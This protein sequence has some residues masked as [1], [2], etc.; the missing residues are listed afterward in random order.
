MSNS[1]VPLQPSSKK[2][3]LYSKWTIVILLILLLGV[4]TPSSI[5][6]VHKVQAETI[7]KEQLH[8][9]Q[10]LIKNLE[11]TAFSDHQFEQNDQG[12]MILFTDKNL[13]DSVKQLANTFIEKEKSD[14]DLTLA[15]THIQSVTDQVGEVKTVLTNYTW[16]SDT[17]S[18]TKKPEKSL[19]PTYVDAT[20]Q[21]AITMQNLVVDEAHLAAIRLAV[22]QKLLDNAKDPDAILD[23][24]LALPD[25]TWETQM[26]YTPT[27]LTITLPDNSGVEEDK[28]TLDYKTIARAINPAY[29]DPTIVA[30]F[31]KNEHTG[32]KQIALTFDDG[33]NPATT[34]SILTTLKAKNVHATFFQLGEQVAMYPELAK[35]VHDEG[36]LIG[37]HTYH[38]L[39]LVTQN[40]D[41]IKEEIQDTDK[42]IFQASGIL[43]TIVRPPYG[44]VNQGVADISG[45]P[46]IQWDIDSL[47]WKTKNSAKT[48]QQI[49][50]SI[51]DNGIILMHDIQPSTAA[52][53]PQLIDWL[54][55]QGYELVTV[56]QL[57]DYDALP[58]HQYF[59]QDDERV[60][61]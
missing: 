15:S 59:S 12:K 1:N 28:V 10:Q 24:V 19:D 61:S 21:Q 2:G 26:M 45:R 30:T 53:L 32:K 16:N 23:Q 11:T 47:D 34:P 52:V 33:P 8:A 48:L 49:Q 13:S 57:L 36:H 14:A 54:Q 60:I 5:Y 31:P 4:I 27:Q 46:I 3:W 9:K 35:Q 6:F 29:V 20:T 38:H 25:F 41:V 50:S 43:P 17:K 22:Q 58:L 42:A 7:A 55:A 40:Q 56:D 18:Y 44:A 39:N 37:S 51:V